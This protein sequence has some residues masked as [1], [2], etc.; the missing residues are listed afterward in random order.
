VIGIIVL[1]GCTVANV[2]TPSAVPV[3]TDA[4]VFTLTT[5]PTETIIPLSPTVNAQPLTETVTS[6]PPTETPL[7]ACVTLIYEE[8]AQFEII[9]PNG[10]RIMI[11]INDPAKLSHPVSASDILLTTH[12][13]WDHLNE[14]FQAA[15]PGLQLF[16]QTGRLEAPG[17]MIQGI[18]SAHNQG[19]LFKPKGGSN[20]IYVIEI[21]GLRIVHFGDIGQNAL[22][23]E[24]L[25]AIGQVDIAITQLNNPYSEMNAENAKGIHLME[26]VEPRLIIPTHINLDT[27]KL[28]VAQWPGWYSEVPSLQ[29]CQSDLREGPEI[30]FLG[31][32]AS[33]MSKYINLQVWSNQ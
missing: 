4:G 5:Q 24:Q 13:H 9:G 10:Q 12:T 11:D 16:V 31:E 28:A 33:T 30:L 29:I 18:A 14:D 1:T 27:A 8:F 15:F 21:G 2:S 17:V 20:Y 32:A 3:P 26:Q 6:L 25:N 7:P 19:D 23:D 22:T